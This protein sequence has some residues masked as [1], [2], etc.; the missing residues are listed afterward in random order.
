MG[1]ATEGDFRA[2]VNGSKFIASFTIDD[3][4]YGCSG[5]IDP[6]ITEFICKTPVLVYPDL[7]FLTAIRKYVGE[8]GPNNFLLTFDNGVTITGPMKE[9]VNPP[10]PI[11]GEGTWIS[12]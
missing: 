5:T 4:L 11:A 8:I 9:E 6:M 10:I 2:V 3:I 1:T 12:S 7:S